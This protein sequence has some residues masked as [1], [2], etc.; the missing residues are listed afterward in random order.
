MN[1]LNGAKAR[2]VE[3]QYNIGKPKE[4]HENLKTILA[5]Y[6]RY[7]TPIPQISEELDAPQVTI[8]SWR[9]QLGYN[10]KRKHEG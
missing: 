1:E 6:E 5:R 8:N 7:G 9:Y 4:E 3:L 10:R 2:L